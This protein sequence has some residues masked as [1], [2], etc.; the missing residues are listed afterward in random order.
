[1]GPEKKMNLP[2]LISIL[3]HSAHRES[4]RKYEL[5][6]SSEFGGYISRN[7]KSY[8]QPSFDRTWEA[9]GQDSLFL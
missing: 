2:N 6:L 1:M 9:L 4:F 7:G 5:N 3:K 8:Q